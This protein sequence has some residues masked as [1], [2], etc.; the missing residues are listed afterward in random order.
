MSK[1]I[2]LFLF[3]VASCAFLGWLLPDQSFPPSKRPP[4][5]V[6]AD[7][8]IDLNAEVSLTALTVT[9]HNVDTFDWLDVI[10]RIPSA[11][12]LD[13]LGYKHKIAV[14][15]SGE[16]LEISLLEFVD[17]KGRRFD[18]LRKQPQRF[19]ISV[20]TPDGQEGSVVFGTR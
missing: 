7:P 5:V 4:V 3:L 16:T 6:E 11:R 15:R 12:L 18:A 20:L 8:I 2:K 1:L 14:I 10:M 13:I 17:S 9:V 19:S